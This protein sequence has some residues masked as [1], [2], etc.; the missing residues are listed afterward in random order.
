MHCEIST[1]PIVVGSSARP[2]YG[3]VDFQFRGGLE[4]LAGA[5]HTKSRVMSGPRKRR[6]LVR[7]TI[8]RR[9]FS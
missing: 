3:G 6:Q 9:L 2:L 7:S 1:G 8:Q 5:D 4:F